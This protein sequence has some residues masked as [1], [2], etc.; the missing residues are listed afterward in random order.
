MIQ[1]A[2]TGM[3]SVA[4]SEAQKLANKRACS[5]RKPLAERLK[6]LDENNTFDETATQIFLQARQGSRLRFLRLDHLELLAVLC[7]LTPVAGEAQGLPGMD[8]WKA[9]HNGN[10]VAITGCFELGHR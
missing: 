2:R 5:N 3:L 8:I 9:T 10:E 6:V 1:V 7:M 4:P